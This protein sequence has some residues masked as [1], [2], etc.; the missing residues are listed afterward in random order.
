MK[1]A[2]LFAEVRA[3]TRDGVMPSGLIDRLQHQLEQVK[4]VLQGSTVASMGLL[5]AARGQRRAVPAVP[6]H[7]DL[8]CSAR[9]RVLVPEFN[10]RAA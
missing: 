2:N 3:L 6:A 4:D 8:R 5:A 10:E 1:L 9:V 7:C